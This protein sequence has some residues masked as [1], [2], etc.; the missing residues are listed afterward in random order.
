MSNSLILTGISLIS[1]SSK[2]M[3]LCLRKKVSLYMLHKPVLLLFIAVCVAVWSQTVTNEDR[4]VSMV[5][6]S[7]HN[8]RALS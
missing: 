2:L 1:W 4:H 6:R 8:G 5:Y 3:E 7:G